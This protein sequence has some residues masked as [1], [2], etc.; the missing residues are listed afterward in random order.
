M[1]EFQIAKE[2]D[3][4]ITGTNGTLYLR[5]NVSRIHGEMIENVEMTLEEQLLKIV[6]NVS[7]VITIKYDTIITSSGTIFYRKI[8]DTTYITRYD[9]V[10]TSNVSSRN[11]NSIGHF[12]LLIYEKERTIDWS[13]KKMTMH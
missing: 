3:S 12:S 6:K 9:T 8:S 7:P 11:T 1:Q 4:L 13:Q 2:K 5:G 10:L